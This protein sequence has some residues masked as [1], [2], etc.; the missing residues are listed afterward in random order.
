MA[1]VNQSLDKSDRLAIIDAEVKVSKR[2]EQVHFR[3][4]PKE[5]PV[6]R[7]DIDLPIYRIKNGRTKV[8]QYQYI[9]TNGLRHDFFENSEEDRSVQQAQEKILLKLSK[10]EKASIYNELK[11][12]AVQTEALLL[13]SHGVVLNGN[14]RLA[15]IRELF[16]SDPKTYQKFSHVNAII[17]PRETN[18]SD[19]E[20]LEAE[21]QLAPETRLEYGWIER[22]LKLRRQIEELGISRSTIKLTYRFKRDQEINVEL[23]QLALA[24]EYLNDYLE[25]P[26]AYQEVSQSEQLFTDLEKAI[27]GK[28]GSEEEVR[29]QLGFLLASKAGNLGNRVYGYKSIFGSDFHPIVKKYSES[30]NIRL[31]YANPPNQELP[32]GLNPDDPLAGLPASSLPETNPDYS[33]ITAKLKE[34]ENATETVEV[35]LEIFE[36]YKEE[37]KQQTS[38][39]AALK[40][41]ER[42]NKIVQSIDLSTAN[43]STLP[44][45]DAQLTAVIEQAS[46][47]KK[48]IEKLKNRPT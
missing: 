10:D 1:V 21:L 42:I 16:N 9:E 15:A 18:E 11:H 19:L 3:N 48:E 33:A 35:L 40:N 46:A 34:K 38:S 12:V 32:T 45:I 25:R 39:D 44:R 36:G 24:E 6:V 41:A 8:E 22:R 23:Q 37:R 28:K 2:K 20:L 27:R 14:R 31:A 43:P 26:L 4:E 17:L 30:Q 29:R 13:T 47:L 5:L 7:L